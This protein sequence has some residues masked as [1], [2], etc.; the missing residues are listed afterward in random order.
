MNLFE[1]ISIALEGLR[2]NKMRTFLTV[3]GIIIGIASVI[4]IVTM[5][6]AMRSKVSSGFDGIGQNL[7]SLNVQ[8]KNGDWSSI[9][10]K[11]VFPLAAVNQVSEKFQDRIEEI[12]LSGAG[13]NGKITKNKNSVNINI[14]STSKGHLKAYKT[15]ILSGRFIN[16]LDVSSNRGVII[17]S[18]KVVE[19]IFNGKYNEALG[20]EISVDTTSG[21]KYYIVVGIYKFEKNALFGGAGEPITAAFIPYTLGNIQFGNGNNEENISSFNILARDRNDLIPLGEEVS[22]YL[23]KLYFANNDKVKIGY[24]TIESTLSQINSIMSSISLAIGGIAAISLLVGGIGVMNIL[25]VSVTE[26]TREIGV[27]KALGATNRDIQ[28]QFIVESIIICI[29]GG[30]IGVVLG[31]LAG[32][33]ASFIMKSPTMPSIPAIIIAVLFS[34]AIG[35]FFGYY[36]ASKAAKLNPIDALRYE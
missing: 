6:D 15:E 9:T 17:I 24:E 32:F 3:L 20:A 2:L 22:E 31:G 8:P 27:R 33:G 13:S 23:N 29:L 34:M 36:P 11:D 18:D 4:T 14:N 28:S 25:L 19:K 21:V 16:D 10:S 7:M 5:G 30:I 26:R 35:I 12:I 1:N